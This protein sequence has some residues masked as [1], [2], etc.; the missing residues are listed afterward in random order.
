[1]GLQTRFSK[2]NIPPE[3]EIICC[4]IAYDNHLNNNDIKKL[5]NNCVKYLQDFGLLKKDTI[6]STSINDVGPV[7]PG[8]YFGHEKELAK[9]NAHLG[10]CNNFYSLGSLADYAYSD[11]QVI[12]AKA[13]DL[14]FELSTIDSKNNSEILKE[15]QKTNPSNKFSF[16]NR[17]ISKYTDEPTFLIAEI[18]LA[19]NGK[20]EICKELIQASVDSGFD[21]VKIQTYSK[22]RISKKTRTSR[23]FEETLGQEEPIAE[24]LDNIIF[25]DNQL[26]EIFEYAKSLNIEMF[27]TPFR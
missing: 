15:N 21:A 16:G 7:Y 6:V 27:S 8:Y 4:E 17:F 20:V 5:E 24:F 26:F 22:G 18:G 13:I 23:Y 11:L 9:V 10:L 3:H 25:N 14:G 1:M 19:H 2:K 12:T